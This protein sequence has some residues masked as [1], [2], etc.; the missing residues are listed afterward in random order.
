MW[1]DCGNFNGIGRTKI[2][3]MVIR[4]TCYFAVNDHW[5]VS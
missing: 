1:N 4:S 3:T 2:K 5:W